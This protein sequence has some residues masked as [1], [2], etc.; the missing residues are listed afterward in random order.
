MHATNTLKQHLS[1]N[2]KNRSTIPLY[3]GTGSIAKATI[4]FSTLL[5]IRERSEQRGLAVAMLTPALRIRFHIRLYIRGA[6]EKNRNR[7]MPPYTT[8]FQ[9][10]SLISVQPLVCSTR[11]QNSQVNDHFK[12]CQKPLLIEE[13]AMKKAS[14]VIMFFTL[15]LMLSSILSVS[16]PNPSPSPNSTT[17]T[18]FLDTR[19]DG[20]ATFTDEKTHTASISAKLVIPQNASQNS[21]AYAAHQ[22]NKTLNEIESFS[23][24]TAYTTALPRFFITLDK[25]NDSAI[26][27]ILLS[28]CLSTGTGSWKSTSGGKNWTESDYELTSYGDNWISLEAWKN[29]YG[30]AKV[31][32]VGVCLEYETVQP[33]GL[34]QPLYV[35]KLVLNGVYLTIVAGN[36]APN[37]SGNNTQPI[38]T[39]TPSPTPTPKMTASLNMTCSSC[40]TQSRINVDIKGY[41]SGND[42]GLAGEP[43]R[44]YY[45]LSGGEKWNELTFVNTNEDGGFSALWLPSAT[46]NLLL[47]AMYE[48]NSLYCAT[49]TIVNL[50]ITQVNS[51][52]DNL[53]SASSSSTLSELFFNSSSSELSF[54]VSGEDGTEGYVDAYIPK[55]LVSNASSLKVYLGNQ[56]IDYSVTSEDDSWLLLYSLNQIPPLPA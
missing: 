50:G 30:N 45:S 6:I 55:S 18:V 43:V 56:E 31:D 41:L 1:L 49:K 23:I 48:G 29:S 21:N 54:S 24:Y 44:L 53:F 5:Y 35:D 2:H 12:R 46:G 15:A 14:V 13:K 3:I 26:D 17:V 7:V 52:E 32:Y 47:K 10:F 36:G 39:P 22:I 25:D 19:S 37:A 20:Q 16:A 4:L 51:Q 27:S 42:T 11:L 8:V 28:Q 9:P 40:I 38:P 34:D 33:D